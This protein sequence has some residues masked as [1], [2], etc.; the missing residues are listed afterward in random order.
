M[1]ILNLVTSREIKGSITV[2]MTFMFIIIFGLVLAL[3]ENT[4]IISSIGY[5]KNASVSAEKALFGDYN[6]E[7][8][9]EYG[10]FGYGGYNG[11]STTDMIDDFKDILM[12]NL[13][14]KPEDSKLSYT[15]IYKINKP[16]VEGKCFEGLSDG[17]NLYRQIKEYLV[18]EA[19]ES[20]TDRLKNKY[21][22]NNISDKSALS[23]KLDAGDSYET[24]KYKEKYKTVE[25]NKDAYIDESEDNDKKIDTVKNE[26]IIEE[27]NDSDAKNE[28]VGNPLEVFKELVEDGYLSLVCDSKQLSDVKIE[29]ALSADDETDVGMTGKE[30][31]I[32]N[33][34]IKNKDSRYDNENVTSTDY[35]VSHEYESAG[36]F[37]KNIFL[38][39]DIDKEDTDKISDKKIAEKDKLESIVYA[40]RVF[41]SYVNN[42]KKAVDYGM[43]YLVCG[44]EKEKDNLAG[45]V[46][47]IIAARMV[48]NFAMISGDKMI[49]SKAL[50]TATAI[51]GVTG[52]EPVIKGV[53]YVI[54]AILAFEESCIDTAALLDGRQIPV[55][56]KISDL[57]IRYE[58]IC[59]ASGKFFGEKAKQYE[60]S[61]GKIAS[62]YIDYNEYLFCFATFVSAEKIKKRIF[63]IIEFD[64]RKRFNESFRV[65]DCIV[66]A[67]FE[68]KYEM[69]L[70]FPYLWN[71]YGRDL[72]Y[73]RF[74]RRVSAEY[75]YGS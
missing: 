19:V 74:E 69:R 32:E 28:D 60:K 22:K 58:E 75:R 20:S 45:V 51:A 35:R 57:K 43:E 42:G 68:I 2:F 15:D 44:N 1:R 54:L 27:N 49:S 65:Y 16:D 18:S 38:N 29:K 5:V 67:D 53:Q 73:R 47:R 48:T 6:R 41:S 30:K 52:I 55:V 62:T 25:S 56:K 17:D 71:L 31:E 23:E 8:F 9:R 14:V 24:G 72:K 37:L 21:S 70:I 40:N 66:S 36:S 26:N 3:F 12:N 46:S 59:L 11:I 64:L 13:S 4:R 10:L 50:A 33:K 34:N 61:D 7:L 63:D 39:A